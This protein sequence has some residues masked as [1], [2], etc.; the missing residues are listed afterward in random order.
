MRL[1]SDLRGCREILCKKYLSECK[2]ICMT[3]TIIDDYLKEKWLNIDIY[4]I[5]KLI[6]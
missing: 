4:D 2:I 1:I 5:K 3:K 6:Q